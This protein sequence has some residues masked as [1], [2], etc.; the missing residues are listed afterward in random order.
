MSKAKL[1]PLI[2]GSQFG[3]IMHN[4]VSYSTEFYVTLQRCPEWRGS[5]KEKPLRFSSKTFLLVKR[6]TDEVR[7]TKSEVGG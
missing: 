5:A 4:F 7:N 3:S 2:L 1:K 6:E